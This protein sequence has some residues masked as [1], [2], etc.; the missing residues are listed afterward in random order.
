MNPHALVLRIDDLT[1]ESFPIEP[2]NH[3]SNVMDM[4]VDTTDPCVI[5][6]TLQTAKTCYDVT[7]CVGFC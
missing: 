4:D 2:P 1:V 5:K 7:V 3:F 6:E